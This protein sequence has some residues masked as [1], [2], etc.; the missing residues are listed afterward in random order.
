VVEV[1]GGAPGEANAVGH[2]SCVCLRRLVRL[3]R[4]GQIFEALAET[5][6]IVGCGCEVEEALVGGGG[7]DDGFGFAVDGE[8]DGAAGLFELLHHF[9]GVVA[10][11]GEG[12]DVLGDVENGASVE[13][14]YRTF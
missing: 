11:G 7:E 10:E 9:D 13:V 2:I 5:F 8:D 6:A 3:S 1:A 14:V 4:C 12:L